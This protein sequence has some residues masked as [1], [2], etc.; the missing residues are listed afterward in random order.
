MKNFVNTVFHFLLNPLNETSFL[1]FAAYHVV[2]NT[3][4]TVRLV[5]RQQQLASRTQDANGRIA[6]EVTAAEPKEYRSSDG[7]RREQMQLIIRLQRQIRIDGRFVHP[8][9]ITNAA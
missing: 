7:Q 2:I 3:E 5:L 9:I 6:G 4:W 8:W 1:L